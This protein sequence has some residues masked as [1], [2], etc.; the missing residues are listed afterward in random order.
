MKI[1]EFYEVTDGDY[2]GMK[3]RL[4][5]DESIARFLKRFIDDSTYTAMCDAFSEENYREVFKQSHTLKGLCA[6]LGLS[7]LQSSISDICESVRNSDPADD[8]MPLFEIAKE[9]YEL[10]IEKIGE[11][12]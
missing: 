9:R 7:S 1:K 6:N 5:K 8:I 12:E 10:V 2:E 3:E 4:S 11:L